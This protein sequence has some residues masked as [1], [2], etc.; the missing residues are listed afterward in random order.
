MDICGSKAVYLPHEKDKLSPH[1]PTGECGD[2]EKLQQRV[3]VLENL[4]SGLTRA[5][6]QTKDIGGSTETYET[7]LK[8]S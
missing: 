7:L 5:T 4:L 1:I 6:I 8:R 2:C 3:A